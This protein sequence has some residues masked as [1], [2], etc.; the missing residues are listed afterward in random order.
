MAE[1]AKSSP[2]KRG[3]PSIKIDMTPMV[4]LAFLLLTFFM[5]AASFNNLYI[6]KVERPEESL[7]PGPPVTSDR[8]VTL[9]LGEKDKIYWYQGI[10][11]PKVFTTDFSDSGIRKILVERKIRSKRWSCLSSLR[12]N[13]D[14]KISL[15]S[16]MKWPSPA[17]RN[18]LWWR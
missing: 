1:I 2:G 18:F 16:W 12:I 7:A 8:V 15:I 11:E 5:L 14:T 6:M 17:S 9:I 13:R 10:E 4:D 3:R